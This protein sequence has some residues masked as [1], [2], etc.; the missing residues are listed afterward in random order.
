MKR[1]ELR[2][3]SRHVDDPMAE[4]DIFISSEVT[5]VI[6]ITVVETTLTTLTILSYSLYS[7]PLK[8]LTMIHQ[9]VSG[10]S[11]FSGCLEICLE[12]SIPLIES[13]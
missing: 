8:F 10:F 1:I 6:D 2:S 7:E 12:Y 13:S 4:N 9:V 5:R 11:S 3:E